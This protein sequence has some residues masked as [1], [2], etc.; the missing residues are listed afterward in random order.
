MRT[1]TKTSTQCVLS[2]QYV[3]ELVHTLLENELSC[4]GGDE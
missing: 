3:L 1:Y 2:T 4:S